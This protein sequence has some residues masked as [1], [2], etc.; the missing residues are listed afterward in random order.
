MLCCT[1]R[2]V[3]TKKVRKILQILKGEDPVHALGALILFAEAGWSIDRFTHI[4]RMLRIWGAKEIDTGK[5]LNLAQRLQSQS[6]L[7]KEAEEWR[8]AAHLAIPILESI[9]EG[10]DE[11]NVALKRLEYAEEVNPK[12]PREWAA[13]EKITR[14]AMEKIYTI[15]GPK[16][17]LRLVLALMAHDLGAK[18]RRSSEPEPMSPGVGK[19]YIAWRTTEGVRRIRD[20]EERVQAAKMMLKEYVKQWGDVYPEP[21]VGAMDE[22]GAEGLGRMAIWMLRS[23]SFGKEWKKRWMREIRKKA[24]WWREEI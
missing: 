9:L 5:I 11:E 4:V 24:R 13:R 12:K 22:I 19:E 8:I 3:I 2:V 1:T 18:D 14:R 16:G 7:E 6:A 23:E 10:Q 17:A 15:R 21:L 20:F